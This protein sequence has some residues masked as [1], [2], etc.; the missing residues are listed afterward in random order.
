MK[1][2]KKKAKRNHSKSSKWIPL[3]S[4]DDWRKQWWHK[5]TCTHSNTNTNQLKGMRDK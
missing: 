5:H 3:T 4:S 1:T 2:K